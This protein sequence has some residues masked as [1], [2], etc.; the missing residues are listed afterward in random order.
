MHC[1][2]FVSAALPR[3]FIDQ[4]SK[5]SFQEV[6][7]LI[8]LN[9]TKKDKKITFQMRE[10]FDIFNLQRIM[11]GYTLS[12][13]GNYNKEQ[14]E[15]LLHQQY[16]PE[17]I[18]DF[19]TTYQNLEDR[20]KHFPKLMAQFYQEKIEKSGFLHRFYSLLHEFNLMQAAFRAKQL[21]RNLE[22][23]LKYEDANEWKVAFLLSQKESPSLTPF[24][25]FE[26]LVSI[27]ELHKENPKTL[28]LEVNKFLFN[29]LDELKTHTFGKEYIY[30]YIA[31]LMIVENLY[32]A[33]VKEEF[34]NLLF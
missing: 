25:G 8:D 20:K 22:T 3:L 21:K 16:L 32:K 30:I 17:Y 28:F 1:Y 7:D 29:K 19:F 9:F 27:L 15:D 34:L 4:P 13:F 5:I 31:K 33:A 23:E 18:F 14:L 10:I 26:P 11:Y 2:F 12:P 24:D 6:L